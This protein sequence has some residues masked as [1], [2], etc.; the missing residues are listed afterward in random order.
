MLRDL[1]RSDCPALSSLFRE[2]PERDRRYRFFSQSVPSPRA[3][4]RWFTKGCRH[5]GAFVR[6]VDGEELVGHA[7]FCPMQANATAGGSAE[8]GICVAADWRGWL[9][10]YL[11]DALVRVGGECGLAELEAEIRTD[12]VE[13]MALV[14]HR[15]MVI[16]GP[17]DP[18][19]VRVHLR[20]A[21][22]VSGSTATAAPPLTR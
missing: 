12:N 21:G 18:Q 16:E 15:G 22:A 19:T 8:L 7:M 5:L 13:M 6:T 4:R 10:A 1:S 9:G 17:H 11:L 20:C 14:R 3:L 2:L